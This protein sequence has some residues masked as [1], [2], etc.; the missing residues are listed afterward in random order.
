M[1][2]FEEHGSQVVLTYES[3]GFI[4][5][6][7][8]DAK[9]KA[10]DHVTLSRVFTVQKADLL[11]SEGDEDFGEDVRRFVIG[12]VNGDYRTMNC[13]ARSCRRRSTSST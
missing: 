4:S 1:I 2:T 3:D 7:W 6:A 5:T 11:S 8:V 12:I 13:P 9:L 10:N